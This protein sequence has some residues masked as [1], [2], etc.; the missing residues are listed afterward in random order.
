M[1]EPAASGRRVIESTP[2]AAEAR[3]DILIVPNAT[4]KYQ[5]AQRSRLSLRSRWSI[6]ALPGTRSPKMPAHIILRQHLLRVLKNLLAA[7]KFDQ[8]PQIHESDLV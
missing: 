2:P 4:I 6:C 7:S 5:T 8:F 3:K 1:G